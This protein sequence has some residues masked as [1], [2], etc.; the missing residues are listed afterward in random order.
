[1]RNS[2][3]PEGT[4]PLTLSTNLYT[5]PVVEGLSQSA[6][7]SKILNTRN[8][9]HTRTLT[10]GGQDSTENYS[11]YKSDMQAS[12][13]HSRHMFD[14]T[15]KNINTLKQIKHQGYVQSRYS[16]KNVYE[17]LQVQRVTNGNMEK[18]VKLGNLLNTDVR[19]KFMRDCSTKGSHS[20]LLGDLESLN[21]A[22]LNFYEQV[23]CYKSDMA[24]SLQMLFESYNVIF[25]RQYQTFFH[26]ENKKEKEYHQ[27]IADLNEEREH[28]K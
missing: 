1:M 20:E 12:L 19:Q 24:V 8:K 6:A 27:K 28:V 10:V 3:Q 26:T 11:V 2:R 16:V 4:N 13:D 17:R 7:I 25:L 5:P 15:K 14:F 22:C 18:L 9:R 23:K 21:K